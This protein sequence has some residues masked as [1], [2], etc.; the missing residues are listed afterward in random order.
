MREEFAQK[1][2]LV[3]TNRHLRCLVYDQAGD[4][5]L[6]IEQCLRDLGLEVFGTN[7][8][9]DAVELHRQQPFDV[10][11]LQWSHEVIS[12]SW[13]L[14]KIYDTNAVRPSVVVMVSDE[15]ASL[16]FPFSVSGIIFKPFS[17]EK[18]IKV[19]WDAIGEQVDA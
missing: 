17:A 18:L 4:L 10:L 13:I 1:I 6:A 8:G 16:V 2:L 3:A 12:G 14:D 5:R 19:V 15:R 9:V 7:S 11:I